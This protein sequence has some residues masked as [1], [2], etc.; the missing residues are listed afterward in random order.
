MPCVCPQGQ[1]QYK[2]LLTELKAINVYQ[3]Q[4]QISK[5]VL[6]HGSLHASL[7]VQGLPASRRETASMRKRM[8]AL[9][10]K[11]TSLSDKLQ[12]WMT[13]PGQLPAE[14]EFE[15]EDLDLSKVFS[16]QDGSQSAL[17]WG[18]GTWHVSDVQRAEQ[19]LLRAQEEMHVLLREARDM[20][21]FY[22]HY[23][24]QYQSARA[25]ALEQSGALS[26]GDE[27]VA[28]AVLPRGMCAGWSTN[29]KCAYARQMVQGR[30]VVMEAKLADLSA[31]HAAAGAVSSW[32]ESVRED[33]FGAA[34]GAEMGAI[35]RPATLRARMQAMKKSRPPAS[36]NAQPG[37][38]VQSEDGSESD[39]A[40]S[41][42]GWEGVEM[43]AANESD[44]DAV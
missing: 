38:P 34:V 35:R 41:E 2:N 31:Q 23:V 15:V 27:Q 42:E 7:D 36:F 9:M 21:Q 13:T 22:A 40:Q 43:L 39:E 18:H 37:V 16:Y 26:Q 32:M 6:H 3:L 25:R 20:R 29:A 1:A 17:P 4:A 8:G 28:T 11:A 33:V 10:R 12:G 30:L 19:T 44:E 14:L 24:S 5:C